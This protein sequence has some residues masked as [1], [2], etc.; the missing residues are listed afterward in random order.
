MK[1]SILVALLALA[2]SS[3]AA[4]NTYTVIHNNDAGAGSLRQAIT[5]ANAHAGADEIVFNNDYAISTNSALPDITPEGIAINVTNTRTT[6]ISSWAG[7]FD[8]LSIKANNVHIKGFYITGYAA[9]GIDITSDYVTIEACR[10]Y[11]NTQDGI[12]I[13]AGSSNTTIK[14][15][16]I[17]TIAGNQAY[18]NGEEGIHS[19]GGSNTMIGG[20]NQSD[21]NIIS[22]NSVYGI[23]L[24]GS[25]NDRIEGNY[26]GLSAAGN[27]AISNGDSGIWS[28]GGTTNLTI[29]NNVISGNVSGGL[30]LEATTGAT[31]EGNYIGFNASGSGAI[32]S[33]GSFTYGIYSLGSNGLRIG[34]ANTS[35]RNY[36][37]SFQGN[38]QGGIFLFMSGW[39]VANNIQNNYLGVSTSGAYDINLANS[40]GIILGQSKNTIIEDNLIAYN[41]GA[42]LALPPFFTGRLEGFGVGFYFNP[43]S[44]SL[45]GNAIRRNRIYSNSGKAISLSNASTVFPGNQ[46]IAAPVL[47]SCSITSNTLTGTAPANSEVEIFQSTGLGCGTGEGVSY[48]GMTTAN[49]SGDFSYVVS[50]VTS[51]TAFAATAT[52]AGNNTSEFS[53]NITVTP[54]T[55]TT[56]TTTTTLPPSNA[57]RVTVTDGSSPNQPA[58]LNLAFQSQ[59]SGSAR[60]I[61]TTAIPPQEVMVDTVINIDVGA[62]N[63]AVLLASGFGEKLPR[64]V[65]IYTLMFSDGTR[66]TGRFVIR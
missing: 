36:I 28:H 15:C 35:Q 64:G 52:D 55:T 18:A 37:G 41:I 53:N 56:S 58:T 48:L 43:S 40:F 17:G 8:G 39:T 3:L 62:N 49:A 30:N 23:R 45:E 5:D 44:T 24:T 46:G 59:S 65:Y 61:I 16:Y 22:G 54:T 47:A 21:R 1:K 14:G 20:P 66:I 7:P 29:V 4:A 63:I 13:N 50:G 11:S 19:V 57:P 34:G 10:I 60:L 38:N 9:D 26:I 51:A 31:I 25:N 12:H 6:T 42:D 32:A 27:S 33:S 2:M